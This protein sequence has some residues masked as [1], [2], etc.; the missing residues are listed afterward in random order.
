MFGNWRWRTLAVALILPAAARAGEVDFERDVAPVLIRRC[1]EC[2]GERTAAGGLVLTNGPHLAQGGDSG[3]AIAP[4]DVAANLLIERVSAGEMPPEKKGRSQRL[5]DE[6][7]EVLRNWVAGGAVWPE[8]RV[9]DPYERTTDVRAGRDFWS[10]QPVRNVDVPAVDAARTMNPIDA[11]I[12]ARLEQEGFQSSPQAD[13][14]TLMRRL[15]YDVIGLPPSFEEIEAFV[16]DP[17]P[18]AYERLVDK[19]LERP[20]FGERWARHWLDVVRY[21]DTSGYERD[22]EKPFA[23]KYRDWVVDAI[24]DDLPYDRFIV[25][26]IAGDELPDRSTRTLIATGMLR[27]GT[28]NDEPNDPQDY[29][30]ERLEDLVDVTS[31]A[32]LGITAKC[33][34]CHDHKFDPIPQVDY[35]RFAA[36]FWAGPIEP[37]DAGLLGGPSDDEIG[38][39][40]VLAWTDLTAS[41]TPLHLLK[42]GDR[43]QPLDEAKPAAPSFAAHSGEFTAPDDGAK[44]TRRRLQLAQ[45]I[46]SRENPLTARVIV[47]RLWQ[48]HF[49]AGLVRSPNNFGFTGDRPTH[50]ELLDWLATQLMASG[51]RLKA[52]HRLMLTSNTYRQASLH[53]Q[54]DEYNTRDSGNKFWWRAER[55][56]LDAEALRDTLLFVSGELD[57]RRGGPGFRPTMSPEA[58]EGLSRKGAAYAASPPEEQ[59]RRS[60]YIFAQRSL[61]TPLLTTFDFSDTTLSCGRRDVTIVAPQALALLNDPFVHERSHAL[62]RRVTSAESDPAKRVATAWRFAL[63]RNPTDSEQAASLQHVES[64]RT[65]F[66]DQPSPDEAAWASLCHVL[67]NLNELAY[68]D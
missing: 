19:L 25:E 34:R 21:A 1:L 27:L 67:L 54:A 44:T 14:R 53:P 4:G 31:S 38:E 68:V 37:R 7:I 51:W 39:K 23:W 18:D 11:F 50:P 3:P 28:W 46:A 64:Q 49:G 57:P 66:A 9:L 36:A 63:G 55:R 20:E 26:Q 6:E 24:N 33:A 43:N 12:L 56:R 62:A 32:F 42:N 29:K 40:E 30:Y 16:A 48:E 58:L 61:L 47:N 13:R 59:R 65:R 17:A 35:Y 22:Q 52:I 60:L 41:P 2:H 8:G 45:W 10:L 15:Y 5:P